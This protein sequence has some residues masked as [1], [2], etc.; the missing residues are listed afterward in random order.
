MPTIPQMSLLDHTT[1]RATFSLTLRVNFSTGSGSLC[2]RC[3]LLSTRCRRFTSRT[4]A[5][6][7]MYLHRPTNTTAGSCQSRGGGHRI[8]RSRGLYHIRICITYQVT[9]RSRLVLLM[10]VEGRRHRREIR[11]TSGLLTVQVIRMR[12]L[13]LLMQ[14]SG[15]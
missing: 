3:L 11:R 6:T 4:R 5:Q 9:C 8:H 12:V 10:R 1:M 13:L 14:R 7:L 2:R 15:G